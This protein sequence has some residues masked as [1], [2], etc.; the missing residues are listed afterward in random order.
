MVGVAGS[1][2]V[3]EVALPVARSPTSTSALTL[4]VG[5][6]LPLQ[7]ALALLMST[8]WSSPSFFDIFRPADGGRI[9]N[10]CGPGTG[11]G[12]KEEPGDGK[13][14]E[15]V[16]TSN[17]RFN[18]AGCSLLC[19]EGMDNIYRPCVAGNYYLGVS[20]DFQ[21]RFEERESA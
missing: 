12:R 21:C 3:G 14:W 10:S 17:P 5:V 1:T 11:G 6:P 8:P 15:G 16:M 4:D 7:D 2:P 18:G 13:G 19:T 20:S 9:A